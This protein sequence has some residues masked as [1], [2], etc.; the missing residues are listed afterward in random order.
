MNKLF[1]MMIG[2]NGDVWRFINKKDIDIDSLKEV[3]N[4]ISTIYRAFN[5]SI[6]VKDFTMLKNSDVLLKIIKTKLN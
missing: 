4:D 1:I 2:I 3:V 5:M 6:R